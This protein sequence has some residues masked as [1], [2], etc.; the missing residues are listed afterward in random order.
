MSQPDF[1]LANNAAYVAKGELLP[2]SSA[3]GDA[4]FV[5]KGQVPAEDAPER[6]A[7]VTCMDPRIDPMRAL[8]FDKQPAAIIRNAGGVTYVLDVSAKPQSIRSPNALI[9]ADA[10]RTLIAWQEL[11]HGKEI[12]VVHHTDCGMLRLSTEEL[13][14]GPK[15][16]PA[17][18]HLHEF[19]DIDE[20]VRRD[21]RWLKER[22]QDGALL[23]GTNIVG[24]MLENETGKLRVV[25]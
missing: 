16:I 9:S 15:N 1:L 5:P 6:Y 12:A 10:L 13:H 2:I 21:V 11:V 8:G 20:G 24:Y 7:V 4:L 19:R 25:E 22:V 3:P 17:G 14:A 23:K 18:L